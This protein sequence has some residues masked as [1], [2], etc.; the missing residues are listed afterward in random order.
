[1]TPQQVRDY[2]PLRAYYPTRAPLSL[3]VAVEESEEFHRQSREMRDFWQKKHWPVEL[4]IPAA[5]DHFSVVNDLQDPQG[6]LVN[7]QL[8]QMQLAFQG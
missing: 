7:H 1:L 6:M 5:L 3:V 2:S 8:S 4:I